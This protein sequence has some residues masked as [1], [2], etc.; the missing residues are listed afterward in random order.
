MKSTADSKSSRLSPFFM[1]G[2]FEV[3]TD[4][5]GRG[6]LAGPVVA[7]AVIFA[8]AVVIAIASSP[9]PARALKFLQLHPGL[10]HM[11]SSSSQN[12]FST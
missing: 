4:E 3:G 7:A 2:A 9:K 11:W 8:A 12:S 6:P 10:P 1:E 5:A